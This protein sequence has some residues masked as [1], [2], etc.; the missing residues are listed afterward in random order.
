MQILLTKIKQGNTSLNNET[1]ALRQPINTGVV[2]LRSNVSV[3]GG[4]L[5]AATTDAGS[6]EVLA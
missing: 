6:G 4:L 1:L 3:T 2:K 5:E